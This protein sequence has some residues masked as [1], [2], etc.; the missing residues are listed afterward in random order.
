MD[1][2]PEVHRRLRR[3]SRLSAFLISKGKLKGEK[4]TL[5]ANFS[6][7]HWEEER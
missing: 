7:K 4:Q 5:L 6:Y 2:K 3:L 1:W